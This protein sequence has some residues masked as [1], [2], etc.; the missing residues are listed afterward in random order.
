MS[1]IIWTAVGTHDTSDG[2]IKGIA[3]AGADLSEVASDTVAGIIRGAKSLGMQADDVAIA[4][5][6]GALEAAAEVSE[7]AVRAVREALSGVI[8][9]IRVEVPEPIGSDGSRP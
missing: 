8:G 3:E 9:G 5:A 2:L 7:D 1:V 4:E 6:T